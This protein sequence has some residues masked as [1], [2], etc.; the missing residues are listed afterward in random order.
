MA[1]TGLQQNVKICNKLGL[2]LLIIL[3]VGQTVNAP[4]HHFER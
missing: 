2:A 1:A 4:T 3:A